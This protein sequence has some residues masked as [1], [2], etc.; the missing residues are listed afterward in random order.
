[1]ILPCAFLPAV[2]LIETTNDFSGVVFAQKL[3]ALALS[4]VNEN[5]TV[6]FYTGYTGL[7]NQYTV[8]MYSP[9]FVPEA[10]PLY[11][12]AAPYIL[13]NVSAKFPVLCKAVQVLAQV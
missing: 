11:T 5:A 4:F 9:K 12:F 8:L 6:N 7:L 3:D 10:N 2:F 13:A 1:M